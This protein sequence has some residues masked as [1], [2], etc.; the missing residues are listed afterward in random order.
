MVP[1]RPP[2]LT[3][4]AGKVNL[5]GT[6]FWAWQ[7]LNGLGTVYELA[8]VTGGGWKERVLHSFANGPDG[9][10][11]AAGLLIDGAGNLYGTASAGGFA[12]N[13]CGV[14]FELRRGPEGRWAYHVLYQF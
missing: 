4:E 13:C 8:P 6:T 3:F 5:F 2:G 9:Y 14:V 11:P 7:V 10:G 1:T 12:S